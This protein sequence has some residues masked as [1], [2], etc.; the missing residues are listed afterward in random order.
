MLI[1]HDGHVASEAARSI[2]ILDGHVEDILDRSQIN[3]IV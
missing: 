1:T 3:D 2:K